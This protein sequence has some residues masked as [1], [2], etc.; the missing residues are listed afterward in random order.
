LLD[1]GFELIA[2][3]D[4]AG[5]AFDSLDLAKR[6]VVYYD[7]F[8]GKASI[9]ERLGKNEDRSILRL[10]Q[11]AR[12]SRLLKVIF[13][14][15][16]YILNDAR[17]VYESLCGPEIEVAKCI[18]R[19]EHYTRGHRA[20]ILY[21]HVYFSDLPREYAVALATGGAYTAIIDHE[22]YSPRIVEW[23]TS[24][25]GV[26]SVPAE[27]FV[28]TFVGLLDNP[29]RIWDHAFN[30]QISQDAQVLLLCL[31]SVVETVAL[32]ELRTMWLAMVGAG[33]PTTVL[34]EH[35]ERFI[36]ALKHL[37][38]SFLRTERGHHETGVT[39]QNPSIRDYVARRVVADSE[40]HRDLLVN[41]QVFEQ[42]NCLVRLDANGQMLREPSS[43]FSDSTELQDVVRRTLAARPAALRYL[44]YG[45]GAKA[46]LEREEQNLGLRLSAAA[47][48][49][50]VYG[51]TWLDHVCELANE[52]VT[53]QDIV[54]IATV[55]AC[56]FLEAIV[57]Q[58][59]PDGGKWSPL[60]QHLVAEIGKSVERGYCPDD[61]VEWSRFLCANE[62]LITAEALGEWRDK[63][64]AFCAEETES[65]TGNAPSGP[66]GEAWFETVESVARRWG[67]RIDDEREQLR[68]WAREHAEREEE[69]DWRAFRGGG[70][71][72]DEPSGIDEDL[73]ALFDSLVDRDR[74]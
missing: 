42:V 19:I 23:M 12:R 50:A 52:Y 69:D 39:F 71:A 15:R 33:P 20:R 13:T 41:S 49:S 16:E 60:I 22:N 35:R 17:R 24:E 2:V 65:I 38:G 67:F 63:A 21:N 1:D 26:R 11:E 27:R 44:S 74:P 9:G 28:D 51:T 6:Q 72:S 48:W 47:R 46:A 30:N 66:D 57:K 53:S 37:D 56:E 14:T 29:L 25:A 58:N 32:D 4:D 55:G 61:W 36:A 43:V 70:L 68:A 34:R 64:R 10:L 59:P 54:R 45:G 7:D 62:R 8:L 31:A 18:V 40:L 3:R 5:E 73:D